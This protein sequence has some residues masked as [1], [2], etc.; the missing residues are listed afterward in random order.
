M[1]I[2]KHNFIR[3]IYIEYIYIE[4]IKELQNTKTK[5]YRK[6]NKPLTKNY[7]EGFIKYVHLH[8]S[9]QQD[10]QTNNYY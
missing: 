8:T 3:N 7:K 10:K 9:T 5:K 6:N 2:R 4:V 1:K